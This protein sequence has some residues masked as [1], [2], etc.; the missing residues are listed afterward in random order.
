MM[1]TIWDQTPG[2]KNAEET[3]IWEEE[4]TGLITR[5]GMI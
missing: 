4:E 5:E 3:S 2:T 1:L